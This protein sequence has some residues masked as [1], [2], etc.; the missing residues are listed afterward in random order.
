MNKSQRR[1]SIV[2]FDGVEVLDFC[3]PFEVFSVTGERQGL[4]PF[5][6]HTVAEEARPIIA[7]GGLHVNPEHTFDDCP[8]P[9]ILVVP[10]GFGTRREMNNSRMLTWLKDKAAKAELVLSVCSGALV[11]G[12]AGLLDGL[13]ATTHHCALDELRAISPQIKI[14]SSRRFIDNGG[15][16]VSAG[17]SAGIDMSLHVVSR[18]LGEDQAAETAK[19]ME[20]QGNSQR[21]AALAPALAL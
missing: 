2:I 14:D 9:D 13:T 11:L 20:Y 1:V 21:Y 15:V 6:V 18:L 10:G 4:K 16:I 7:R 19:Y 5:V 12:K 17:I 8:D 3:G